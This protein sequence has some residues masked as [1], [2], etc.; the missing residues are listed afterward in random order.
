MLNAQ[1]HKAEMFKLEKFVV[2]LVKVDTLKYEMIGIVSPIY[3]LRSPEIVED[4]IELLPMSHKKVFLIKTGA[5]YIWFNQSAS[6]KNI[7]SLKKKWYD[8]FYERTLVTC[9]NWL[10]DYDETTVK[11]LYEVNMS[12]KIPAIAKD[13]TKGVRRR[14]K[15]DYMRDALSFATDVVGNKI[16]AKLFGRSIRSTSACTQCMSCV[17]RCPMN[18]LYEKN[19]RIRGSWHCVWCMKC[20]YGCKESA[21]V[22]RGLSIFIFRSGFVYRFI[23]QNKALNTKKVKVSRHIWKYMENDKI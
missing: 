20:V 12:R 5:D 6:V 23:M 14:Y 17:K 13:L 9:S 18:N 22:S 2:G 4:F 10:Y 15:R 8:V 19:S 11:R 1:N 7:H 21:L 16:L 3:S